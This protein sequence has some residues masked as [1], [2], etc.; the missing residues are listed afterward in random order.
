M[1]W[2]IKL[3]NLIKGTVDIVAKVRISVGTTTIT[4]SAYTSAVDMHLI[5]KPWEV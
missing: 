4:V 3:G 2:S 1:W 5:T